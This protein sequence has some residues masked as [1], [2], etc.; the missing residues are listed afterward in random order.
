MSAVPAHYFPP[1]ES[2][3]E[4]AIERLAAQLV[5]ED[6]VALLLTELLDANTWLLPLLV[7]QPPPWWKPELTTLI[8]RLR[9]LEKNLG[10][11]IDDARR[12]HMQDLT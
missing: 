5:R 9:S 3:R 8:Q 4:E 2:F 6:E 10:G 7:R 12:R 1:D 11:A